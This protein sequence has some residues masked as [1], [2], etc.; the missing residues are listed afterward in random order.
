M[1]YWYCSRPLPSSSSVD[2]DFAGCSMKFLVGISV[3]EAGLN[4]KSSV[5]P[6]K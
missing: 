3:L 5:G 6:K 1:M 4:S 2:G